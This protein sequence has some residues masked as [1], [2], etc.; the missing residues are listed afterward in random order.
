[1][2]VSGKD[3]RDLDHGMG[4]RHLYH[5]SVIAVVP[6]MELGGQEKLLPRYARL[7][8]RLPDQ[9]FPIPLL[10]LHSTTMRPTSAWSYGALPANRGK[11]V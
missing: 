3:R 10:R 1:M 6:G 4:G 8:H 11:Y 5:G 7:N 9:V 2:K